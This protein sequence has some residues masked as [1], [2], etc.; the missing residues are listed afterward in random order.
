MRPSRV[1]A[2]RGPATSDYRRKGTA[3][4]LHIAFED[5]FDH[6]S[7]VV[8]VDGREVSRLEGLT[9]RYQIS[10]ARAV[11]FEAEGPARV[12]V[13]VPTRCLSRWEVVP[14]DAPTY[15]AVSIED[16]GLSWRTQHEPYGYV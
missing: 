6:D 16:D 9:T 8:K 14:L 4:L 7:A 13:S 11:D 15:V 3:T 1:R 5:G 10:L 12:E 2:G